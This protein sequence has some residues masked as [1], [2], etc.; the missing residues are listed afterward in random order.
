MVMMMSGDDGSNDDSHDDADH[1]EDE[2]GHV[3]DDD[4]MIAT[5]RAIKS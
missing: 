5:T 4:S 1:D 2:D 3:G